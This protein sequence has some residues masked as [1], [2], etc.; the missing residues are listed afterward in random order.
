[1]PS[2]QVL[3]GEV[4]VVIGPNGSGKTT[5]LLA[6]G[7]LDKPSSGSVRYRGQPV[8]DGPDIL[9]APPAARRGLPGAAAAEHCGLG[10]CR[11]WADHARGLKE[12]IRARARKMAGAIRYRSL[13]NRQAKTLSGGEAKRA[14]LARAFAL[15][16]EVLFL[17]EPFN[18]LD[19][20]TRQALIEDF[21][22][23]LRRPGSL[24][25]W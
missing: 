12:E 13:A 6:A 21:E 15:E 5:L 20:P 14:S 1:M 8:N 11:L 22:R 7:Q 9:R 17:D 16:P 18:G 24:R 19:T 4:L 23:V 3:P 25:S 10:Q 2:L